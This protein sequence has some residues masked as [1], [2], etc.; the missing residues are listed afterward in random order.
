M[1]QALTRHTSFTWLKRSLKES[2]WLYFQFVAHGPMP[3][4]PF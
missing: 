3:T 2:N 1:R 4:M